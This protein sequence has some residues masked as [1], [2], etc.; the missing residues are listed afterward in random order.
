MTVRQRRAVHVRAIRHEARN[1][2]RLFPKITEGAL[3][4]II[5]ESVSGAC[6][7]TGEE[8]KNNDGKTDLIDTRYLPNATN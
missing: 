6:R 2:I 4:E 8:N 3:L 7:D 1:W 5:D